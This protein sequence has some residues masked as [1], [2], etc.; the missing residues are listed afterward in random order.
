MSQ[1]FS[2][3]SAEWRQN[4]VHLQSRV[5][6][7]LIKLEEKEKVGGGSHVVGVHHFWPSW[8]SCG[9]RN[10]S[11]SLVVGEVT[12]RTGQHVVKYKLGLN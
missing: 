1:G 3:I 8:E 5:S 12:G 6:F 11:G 7:S 9:N 2:F 4:L 10:R